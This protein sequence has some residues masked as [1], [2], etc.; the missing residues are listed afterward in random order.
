MEH[1]A[2]PHP[3]DFES[4]KQGDFI[5]PDIVSDVT[6]ISP[7]NR[8]YGLAQLKA[9]D[10]IESGLADCGHCWILRSEGDGLRILTDEEASVYKE[11]MMRARIRGFGRDLRQMQHI[12]V[13]KLTEE[14][15]HKHD[16]HM[17]RASLFLQAGRNAIR[18]RISAASKSVPYMPKRIPDGGNNG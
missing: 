17:V 6:G 10:I 13:G 4:L 11:R 1:N 2:T 8:A 18:K 12:D 5:A 7:K 9:R 14:R 16:E 3:I 15:R